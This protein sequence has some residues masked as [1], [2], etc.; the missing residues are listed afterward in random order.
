MASLCLSNRLILGWAL[1]PA[2]RVFTLT[3]S[4]PSISTSKPVSA[5]SDRLAETYL[6]QSSLSGLMVGPV[7]GWRSSRAIGAA[8]RERLSA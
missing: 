6:R 4:S 5:G 7:G 8:M 3:S 2:G 1:K